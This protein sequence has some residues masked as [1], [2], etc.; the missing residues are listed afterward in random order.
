MMDG[1]NS[2][3]L[4]PKRPAWSRPEVIFIIASLTLLGSLLLPIP[5]K[6]LDILWI[7]A[8][9]LAGAVTWV[10]VIA[11]NS[12]DLFGFV[13]LISALTLLRLVL[14]SATTR[15]IIE[16]KSTGILLT[17][18][19]HALTGNWALGAVL[20]C[21]LLAVIIIIVVFAACHQITAATNNYTKMI[22]PLKRVGI[23]FDLRAGVID[24]PNAVTL[25]RRIVSEFR[26]FAGMNG[27]SLLMRSE[28]AICILI[29]LACLILPGMSGSMGDIS[30]TE[31]IAKTA[32]N[33]V[34]LSIFTLIPALVVAAA[35]GAL[36]CKETLT[37]RPAH[38]EEAHPTKKIKIISKETGSEEEIE[39]L[40]PDFLSHEGAED[41]LVEFTPHK[42]APL[43][44]PAASSP[45]R[46]S[47]P[48]RHTPEPV[49]A[50]QP[51][52]QV[53]AG[54]RAEPIEIPCR[55][56]NEYYEKLAR[57]IAA[58][59]M[60][61]RTIMLASEKLND[62]PV[63]VAV[64]IAIRLAQQKQKVLL[65]DTDT[66]RNA[67][68]QVF[69]LD[70]ET[71]TKK[72]LSSCFEN[73]SVCTV[74]AAKLDKLLNK[75]KILEHFGTTLIY[76]PNAVRVGIMKNVELAARPTAFY[77]TDRPGSDIAFKMSASENLSF[78]GSL[79]LIPSIQ[80]IMKP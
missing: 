19:G 57:M 41:K 43:P 7:F 65:V 34:A 26:F 40:N 42:P 62:L 68:A 63:T 76:T 72:V 32:P 4:E 17:S 64:N 23:E 15:R 20:I 22:L 66:E 3:D 29:L 45:A 71:L 11:K 44:A 28:A 70:P 58:I 52:P 53:K 12:T 10:C 9:M 24:G 49:P 27:T 46:P 48:V 25:A 69:E 75:T 54:P 1:M 37:I 16:N 59:Q 80:A 38:P 39:L 67:M 8:F 50:S 56:A 60:Q 51:E 30:G 14:L 13:P 6:G 35:C 47:E 55:N 61:P 78:C 73:L 77:F 31:L 5:E 2:I 18:V 33:V 79:K 21:L 36:M 74:P